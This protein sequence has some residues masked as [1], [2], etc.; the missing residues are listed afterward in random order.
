[1]NRKL[2]GVQR[3]FTTRIAGLEHLNYWQRISRLGLYSLE[4]RRERYVILYIFKIIG[5]LVPNVGEHKFKVVINIS[6][7]RGRTCVI[8]PLSGNA[9]S[10]LKTLIDDSFA[11]RGAKLFNVLQKVLR[12]FEG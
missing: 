1:M 2:E 7:R 6:E 8:P 4:R 12:N 9:P 11:I 3:S 10:R 5:K